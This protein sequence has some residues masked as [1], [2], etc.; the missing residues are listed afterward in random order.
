MI[1]PAYREIHEFPTSAIRELLLTSLRQFGATEEADLIKDVAN[2][3]GSKRTGD[4]IV[5]KVGECVESLIREG[6][7]GQE[8][9]RLQAAVPRANVS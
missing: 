9:G 1:G 6:K 4:R 2:Q 7:V 3:L 8:G 5:R